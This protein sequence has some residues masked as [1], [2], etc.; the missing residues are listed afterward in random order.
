MIFKLLIWF[1]VLTFLM[2]IIFLLTVWWVEI[3]WDLVWK[4]FISYII[5]SCLI[6]VAMLWVKLKEDNWSTINKEWKDL[7]W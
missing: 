5:V 7:V 4:L 1:L 3:N 2:W 6:F